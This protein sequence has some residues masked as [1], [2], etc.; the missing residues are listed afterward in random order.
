MLDDGLM[1]CLYW[2]MCELFMNDVLRVICNVVFVLENYVVF[3]VL[4]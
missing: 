4:F 2:M 1:L 3:L